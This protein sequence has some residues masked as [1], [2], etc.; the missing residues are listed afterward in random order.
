MGNS[1]YVLMERNT[2]G[3]DLLADRRVGQINT[4]STYW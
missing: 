2:D 4:E 1:F 3:M